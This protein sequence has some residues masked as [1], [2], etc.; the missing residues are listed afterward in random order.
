MPRIWHKIHAPLN[1]ISL[2][3]WTVLYKIT[4]ERMG[5]TAKCIP[6]LSVARN[7]DV[8]FADEKKKEKKKKK[9]KKRKKKKTIKK[10]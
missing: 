7:S 6:Q 2:L 1:L 9:K 10:K 8:R 3:K 4:S 5:N